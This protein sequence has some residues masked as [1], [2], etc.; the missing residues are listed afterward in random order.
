MKVLMI[1][2]RDG[3]PI[4]TDLD[5]PL[6]APLNIYA[7]QSVECSQCCQRH[8]LRK[9]Y[10]ETS[11]PTEKNKFNVALESVPVYAASIGILI[12]CYAIIEG[13]IP[14]LL[15]RLINISEEDSKLILGRSQIGERIQLVEALA[16]T[17]DDGNKA[18][19]A[20][21][22][23]APKLTEATAARNKYA[24]SQYSITFNDAVIVKSWIHDSK[25]KN[26]PE[27]VED[28]NF[29]SQEIEKAQSLI[30][31]LH[32]YVYLDEMPC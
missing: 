26:K 14:Q 8:P 22:I 16:K 9:L 17:K 25:K 24:H 30:C 20:I 1:C 3:K 21:E 13:Y 4:N 28:I 32:K 7:N 11:V 23:F 12:S 19:K 18:K 29:I 31:D 5:L 15:S 6:E 10:F 27:S 2:P